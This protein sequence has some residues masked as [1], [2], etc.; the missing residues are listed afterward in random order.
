MRH[1]GQSETVNPCRTKWF[2]IFTN[3]IAF[4]ED[5]RLSALTCSPTPFWCPQSGRFVGPHL[6]RRLK[7]SCRDVPVPRR[8]EVAYPD[9]LAVLTLPV[10][11]FPVLSMS[12]LRL[13]VL[14][15]SGLRLPVLRLLVLRLP[16]LRLPVLGL[17]VLWLRA[18]RLPVLRLPVLSMSVLNRIKT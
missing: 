15:M 14:S 8:P 13:P 5:D 12:V 2:F 10:Q 17:S 18:L 9:V 6:G 16:V 7:A 11:R 4:N 3:S 1:K